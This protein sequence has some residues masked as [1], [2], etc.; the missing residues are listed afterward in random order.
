MCAITV[1]C[2]GSTCIREGCLCNKPYSV[3][4]LFLLTFAGISQAFLWTGGHWV[5]SCMRCW[6]ERVRLTSEAMTCQIRAQRTICFKV[7]VC[8]SSQGRKHYHSSLHL[9]LLLPA[10]LNSYSRKDN[11][12]PSQSFC[13]GSTGKHT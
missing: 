4:R 1:R 7:S 5:C 12:N 10:F 11:S 13:E 3:D 8:F 9:P 6:P 2:A